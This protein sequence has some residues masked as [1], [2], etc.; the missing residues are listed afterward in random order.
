MLRHGGEITV[1]STMGVGTTFTITLP[2]A[3]AAS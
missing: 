1:S 2:A 3:G